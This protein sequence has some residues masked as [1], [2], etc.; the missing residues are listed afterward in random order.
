[1]EWFLAAAVS[2]LLFTAIA[3]ISKQIMD[4]I[5]AVRFTAIYSALAFIFYTPVFLYYVYTVDFSFTVVIIALTVLSGL[6][7]ILGMLSYNFGLSKTSISVAMPLNRVQPVIVGVIGVLILG[8]A[9]SLEKAV[10]IG[11]VTL[12]CY[13]ILLEG[14]HNILDPVKN[15]LNDLGAQLALISAFIFSFIS[16][17]DRYVTSQFP[18]EI[19]TFFILGIMAA[20][21]NLYM[22]KIG[23]NYVTKACEEVAN[24]KSLY[25]LVASLSAIAYL[26]VYI[27]FSQAEASRVVPVL[28]LQV[29]LTVI[30]GREIFKEGNTLQKL[31]GSIIL[32]AGVILVI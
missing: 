31:V 25:T 30:L 28:Q 32:I 29:P 11:L 23:T 14:R 21:L 22:V 26:T 9:M 2:A 6:G 1:M 15:L 27:A 12:S 16:L 5:D 8:E 18:P 3:V 24:N 4:H 13:I 17:A 7:N 10:G 19:Y 20:G